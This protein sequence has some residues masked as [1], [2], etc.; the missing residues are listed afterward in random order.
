MTNHEIFVIAKLHYHTRR[1]FKGCYT[2][3][4]LPTIVDYPTL[5]IC[6]KSLSNQRGS[7][8]IGICCLSPRLPSEMFDSRAIGMEAYSILLEKFLVR[9]GN[10]SYKINNYEY[11]PESSDTCG[12]YALAFL[13]WRSQG[14]SYEK[15]LLKLS[16]TDLQTNDQIVTSYVNDHMST[17]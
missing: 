10:G 4:T 16:K 13:D 1:L 3:D 8:W 12:Y 14:V 9:T 2:S 15:C 5:I 6:N 11:Q 7:H 17:K